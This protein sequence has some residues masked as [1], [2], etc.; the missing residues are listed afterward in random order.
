MPSGKAGREEAF[1]FVSPN[2]KSDL[3]FKGAVKELQSRQQAKLLGASADIH[4]KLGINARDTSIVGAWSDGA[5]NS[6]MTRYNADWNETLLAGVMKAHLADQKAVLVF[7]PAKLGK[8]V[9][10]SFKATGD[11]DA[12]YKNLLADG[13]ENHTIDP[14]DGGAMVH[15]VDLDGSSLKAIDKGAAR[16]GQDNPVD[17]QF[18]RGEFIGTTKE[19]GTDREQRDSARRVYQSYIDESPVPDAATIWQDINN[20]WGSAEGK[21]GYRLTSNAIIAETGDVKPNSVAVVDLAKRLNTRAGKIL[22]DEIG[23]SFVNEDTRTDETDDYLA[24]VIAQEL[25]DGLHNGRSGADWYDQTMKEAMDIAGEIYP[26]VA[27]DPDKKFA[28]TAALAITSQGEVVDAN[29]RL[30]DL[31]YSEFQET[32][33]FPTNLKVADPNI[34]SNFE[35][36]NEM[37]KTIG[38]KKTR[39]FFAREMTVGDLKKLT[40]KAPGRMG[41]K[42]MVYGSAILGPKIGQGFYQNLNGNF[43]PITMDLWFMRSW[44]RV[45]NTGIGEPDMEKVVGRFSDFMDALT[46]ANMPVP[47]TDKKKLA[48]AEEIYA[49]HERDYV[50]YGA[51]FKSGERKKSE[52][53]RAAERYVLNAAGA[54]VETPRGAKQRNWII[55]VFDRALEKLSA[56][57]IHINPASAQATWWWP[58]KIL[59]GQMGVRVKELDTDYAKS[60]TKLKQ[61][62]GKP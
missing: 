29:I 20:R 13:I 12:I 46:A 50:K 21:V 18:G 44:G 23:V 26:G 40:G 15:V 36:V 51:E 52:V 54:M 55:S 32:G 58:E 47:R 17:I 49:Q 19:D 35:K 38:I 22:K 14:I 16:Y 45:T 28:Y 53:V 61:T 42:D 6:I 56:Q 59:Y 4:R 57:G 39:E 30:A 8:T 9:L 62:K 7:Q 34:N 31:A 5:E 33:V 60:L 10:A 11:L 43:K 3:D 1:S 48:L 2:V 37:L 27:T 25:V 24:T 41:V